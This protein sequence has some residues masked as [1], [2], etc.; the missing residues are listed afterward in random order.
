MARIFQLF[1]IATMLYASF[2]WSQTPLF[3]SRIDY[4]TSFSPNCICKEDF[5]GD[6]SV[7]LAAAIFSGDNISIFFNDGSGIFLPAVDYS[8]GNEPIFIHTADFN[9]DTSPDLAVSNF[10][11]SDPGGSLSILMNNGDGTFTALVP[12]P[13]SGPLEI[14]STD[15]DGDD[16]IDLAVAQYRNQ[17]VA[18]LMNDGNGVFSPTYFYSAGFEPRSLFQ[19]DFDGDNDHDLVIGASAPGLTDSLFLLLNDGDGSFS[20]IHSFAHANAGND[21]S[22]GDFDNDNDIDLAVCQYYSNAITIYANDGNGNFTATA[23]Y[24]MGGEPGN[25]TVIDIDTDNDLD[26]LVGTSGISDNLIVVKNDGNGVFAIDGYFDVGGNA[27]RIVA[28]DID[29]DNDDDVAV[30]VAD[31]PRFAIFY[32]KG[33]GELL[34][35]SQY[36]LP[37]GPKSITSADFDNDGDLDLVTT[38]NLVDSV[39]Y[40]ENNGD[41]TYLPRT[42]INFVHDAYSCAAADFDH[43]GNQDLA[44]PNNQFFGW[45][46]LQTYKGNGDGTFQAP[47]QLDFWDYNFGSIRA[48]DLNNDSYHDIALIY[49]TTGKYLTICLNDGSGNFYSKVDYS[50]SYYADYIYSA[51]LDEDLDMDLIVT[52]ATAYGSLYFF[53]NNGDGSFGDP[54]AFDPALDD[55]SYIYRLVMADLNSDH[56]I[57]MVGTGN[58]EVYVALGNGDGTFQPLD[59][60]TGLYGTGHVATADFD[61][62]NDI[63]IVVSNSSLPCVTFLENIG[64]GL[65]DV[66]LNYGVGEGSQDILALNVDGDCDMDI[67]V[68]AG[69]N[70]VT[71][72]KNPYSEPGVWACGDA[73]CDGDVNVADAVYLITYVFKGGSPP[74]PLVAGDANCDSEPNVGDAVYLIS[75]VFKSGPAPCEGCE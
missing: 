46:G 54:I 75:Y 6:G 50:A 62:D 8:V 37:Q 57:D 12:I 17:S 44:V 25:V 9:N 56:H 45:A 70:E 18:I 16:D 5:D 66:T 14:V 41:G 65:F 21:I 42:G 51:D 15:F 2:A 69:Y 47:V 1:V 59:T 72:I 33:Y 48:V 23:G 22:G 27:G 38:S 13:L 61:R 40:L 24:S 39:V 11:N 64:G 19:G 73:N 34:S 26:L 67:V 10:N 52:T 36:S 71:V 30:A 60:Y 63:D 68:L 3:D 29:N 7:D 31:D 58:G 4:K 55:G 43:D 28:M 35:A 20:N 49:G 53:I 32:H 74:Q